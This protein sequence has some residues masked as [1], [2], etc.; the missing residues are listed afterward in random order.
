MNLGFGSHT[1]KSDDSEDPSPTKNL[2][3]NLMPKAGYFVVNNLV[4]GLDLTFSTMRMKDDDYKY[5]LSILGAGP[6]VRYYVP[7]EKVMPFF[8]L[9]GSL[10]SS[11]TKYS[12][13]QFEDEFKSSV[14]SVGGGAGV[15]ILLGRNV[16]FDLLA[17]YSR[18][19][20]KEKEDNE[21][22][23]RDIYNSVGLKLGFTIILGQASE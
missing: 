19:V 11:R 14:N 23:W 6:F 3:F 12:S 1:S 16:T 10:G 22:N 2:H 15:A 8:E 13:D 7:L 5:N 17:G 4:L 18:I 9:N 21:D 20:V